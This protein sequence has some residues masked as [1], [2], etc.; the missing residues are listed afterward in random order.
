M[1]FGGIIAKVAASALFGRARD[2][3]KLVPRKVWIAL[4]VV[5]TL[6]AAVW[7]HQKQ[8]DSAY[9]DAFNA[10]YAER[11]KDENEELKFMR[12]VATAWRKEYEKKATEVSN[13][14]KELHNETIRANS[15][16]ADA[17]RVRGPGAAASCPRP[18]RAAGL[19][20]PSGEHGAQASGTDVAGSGMPA[21][22]WASVPWAWLVDRAETCDADRDE[23]QRWR[24]WYPQQRDLYN[25]ERQRIQNLTE[26]K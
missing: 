18:D 6:W 5:I 12:D 16:R 23:V 26:V 4:A 15:A 19:S 9:H 17:L 3:L 7:L 25:A 8:V 22:Q 13:L 21:E 20:T 10:G 14:Q 2:L 24:N 11:E 1:P